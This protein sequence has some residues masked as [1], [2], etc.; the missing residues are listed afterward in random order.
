[1]KNIKVNTIF[2][3]CEELYIEHLKIKCDLGRDIIKNSRGES[4]CTK[5][6]IKEIFGTIESVNAIENKINLYLPKI[7][8]RLISLHGIGNQKFWKLTLFF[9]IKDLIAVTH[10][11]FNLIE[12]AFDP[13]VHELN[14]AKLPEA[15]PMIGMQGLTDISFWHVFPQGVE[16]FI[17]EYFRLFYSKKYKEVAVQKPNIKL[18][19]V[20]KISIFQKFNSENLLNFA[21]RKI[22]THF[23]KRV[24]V[25]I[26][27]SQVGTWN[28]LKLFLISKGRVLNVHL[29]NPENDGSD[30]RTFN[31][32][33]RDVLTKP[34]DD[35]NNKYE[36]YLCKCLQSSFPWN[37]AEGFSDTYINHENF[38]KNFPNLNTVISEIMYQENSMA[39]AVAQHGGKEIIQMSHFFPIE[40]NYAYKL[41]EILIKDYK[42]VSKGN[43]QL[44]KFKGSISG[45]LFQYKIKSRA[46]S[47]SLL[48]ISTDF[49]GNFLPF[50]LSAN[51]NGY[52]VA[53]IYAEFVK[54]IFDNI[55]DKILNGI[56]IK[57]R[58]D[59][60]CNPLRLQYRQ[61]VKFINRNVPAKDFI[62][63]SKL[64]L[65]EGMSTSFFE[66]ISSN[67]PT[68]AFWPDIYFSGDD[69]K[70][71]WED[72]IRVGVIFNDPLEL[73][74]HLEKIYT[75]PDEWWDSDEVQTVKND[76][77]D[78]HLH[79]NAQFE[80]SLLNYLKN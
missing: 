49:Y 22:T 73:A 10:H 37:L 21:Y 59:H 36:Q 18:K 68:I 65:V 9:Y 27:N 31:L 40:N 42:K 74:H 54:S 34:F 62:A 3:E 41:N 80:K 53:N 19:A 57:M 24:S 79:Q 61:G 71:Y 26:C 46:K 1:M 6:G 64:V 52:H 17:G 67:I 14:I 63:I 39:L 16:Y 33:I 32:E 25:I 43:F 51:G 66:S 58:P 55:S 13:S 75:N 30:S 44:K 70:N 69:Y 50:E 56:S 60:I 47:I 15:P 11:Y 76:F 5:D 28:A 23:H 48:Y 12:T 8:D 72:L 77:L 20:R 29:I 4:C 7:I 2:S 78:K 45:S 38:W 35:T